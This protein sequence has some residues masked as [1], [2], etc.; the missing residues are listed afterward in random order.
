MNRTRKY[1]TECFREQVEHEWKEKFWKFVE[2]NLEQPWDWRGLSANP[3]IT[4]DIVLSH[5][6]QPWSWKGLSGW[7]RTISNVIFGLRDK[8]PQPHSQDLLGWARTLSNVIFG[9]CDK[10][11]ILH[12]QGLSG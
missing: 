4:F 9:F 5:T 8:P 1:R 7:A 11:Y 10:P 6:E 2:D 3:N 12:F